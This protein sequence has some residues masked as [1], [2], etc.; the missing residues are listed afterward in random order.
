MRIV[1]SFA[2]LALLLAAGCPGTPPDSQGGPAP[3][4][5]APPPSRPPGP[6]LPPE[7][8]RA[9][10]AAQLTENLERLEGRLEWYRT[11]KPDFQGLDSAAQLLKDARDGIAGLPAVPEDSMP[12]ALHKINTMMYETEQVMPEPE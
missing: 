4:S 9:S 12:M 11:N 2:L 10:M 5:E 3:S 8:A 1:A 6:T 7:E